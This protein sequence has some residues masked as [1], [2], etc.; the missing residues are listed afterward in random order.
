MPLPLAERRHLDLDDTDRSRNP[1]AEEAWDTN[2][3]PHGARRTACTRGSRH[4]LPARLHLAIS[5]SHPVG[6]G[7]G[8][9]GRIYSYLLG[10]TLTGSTRFVG[11]HIGL[12]SCLFHSAGAVWPL[13]STLPYSY[14]LRLSGALGF[15]RNPR[16]CLAGTEEGVVLGR[17]VGFGAVPREDSLSTR[18][19]RVDL[20]A[21]T[22]L[23][24]RSESC[25]TVTL[26]PDRQD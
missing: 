12:L 15:R 17:V 11:R 13:L 21:L 2:C 16:P 26:S 4:P 14:P 5:I 19:L 7:P 22:L 10:L 9:G 18:P 1:A 23:P 3:P 8:R 24:R 25:L 6:S 20:A